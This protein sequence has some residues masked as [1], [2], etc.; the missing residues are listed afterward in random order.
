MFLNALMLMGIGGAA[1]PLV[2]HLLSRSRY[3]SV[4]WGAMMFLEGYA[5]SRQHQSTRL[6]QLVLVVIRMAIVAL[7]AVALARPV[8]RSEWDNAAGQAS[9]VA[10]VLVVDCSASMAF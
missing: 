1:I 4:D 8:L 9:R 6:N 7:L 3:K 2:L 5:D 10:A